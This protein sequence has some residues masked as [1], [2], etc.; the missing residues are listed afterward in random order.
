LA[1]KTEDKIVMY[2]EVCNA[3]Q[4]PKYTMSVNSNWSNCCNNTW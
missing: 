2:T 3:D 1:G 4:S